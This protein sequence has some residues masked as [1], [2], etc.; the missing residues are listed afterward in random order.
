MGG[1]HGDLDSPGG[2]GRAGETG[3]EQ[4]ALTWATHYGI[5]RPGE[6]SLLPAINF[7]HLGGAVMRRLLLTAGLVCAAIALTGGAIAQNS[8]SQTSSMPGQVVSNT[9]GEKVRLV[10]RDLPQVAKPVGRQIGS[11]A[12]PNVVL[13]NN[14]FES[15]NSNPLGGTN[16]SMSSVVVP[17]YNGYTSNVAPS[18]VQQ[19]F[20]N[21]M[22]LLG[23]KT[24]PTVQ[25][26]YT[27]GIY[28]RDRERVKERMFVRD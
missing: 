21:A 19:V 12:T 23:L 14:P 8:T 9:A 28:R 24:P 20:S 7:T 25:Q 6:I 17:N 27:P 16:L 3:S 22:T 26:I 10:G 13:A 5:H 1:G 2:S 4:N 18:M 11:G 15:F